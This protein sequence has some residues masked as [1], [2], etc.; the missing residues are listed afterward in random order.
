M[1]TTKELKI[2]ISAE[3]KALKDMQKEALELSKRI[4]ELNKAIASGD[5]DADKLEKELKE[6]KQAMADLKVKTNDAKSS[7]KDYGWRHID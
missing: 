6:A 2:K 1:S 4:N 3:T 5:G 7:L